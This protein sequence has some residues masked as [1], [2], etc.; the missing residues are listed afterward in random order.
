MIEKCSLCFVPLFLMIHLHSHFLFFF[1]C[2]LNCTCCVSGKTIFAKN[3]TSFQYCQLNCEK[4]NRFIYVLYRQYSFTSFRSRDQWQF[5]HFF[6]SQ[7]V[8]MPFKNKIVIKHQLLKWTIFKM[9]WSTLTKLS[10][11][12]ISLISI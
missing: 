10:L 11:V 8:E 4:I 3:K 6:L 7:S 5:I 9:R 12:E 1:L 2:H